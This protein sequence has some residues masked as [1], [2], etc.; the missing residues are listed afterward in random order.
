MERSRGFEFGVALGLVGFWWAL[1]GIGWLILELVA[2]RK[3][4]PSWFCVFNYGF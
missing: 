2:K 3:T 1:V 4:S